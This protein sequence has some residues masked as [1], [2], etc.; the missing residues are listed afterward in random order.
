MTGTAQENA[1]ARG[2]EPAGG[3]GRLAR[4]GLSN[5]IQ[6]LAARARS[7]GTARA[8]SR[9]AAL[10]LK[11]RSYS[12]LA[13][14]CVPGGLSQRDLAEYLCLDPSQIVALVDGL[15]QRGLVERRADPR[16]RRSRVI[17][18]TAAGKNLYASATDAVRRAE[19]V[20][21]RNLTDGERNR[22][23]GLLRKMAL[24]PAD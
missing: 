7:L 23:R 21:L 1:A 5:E 2:R 24:T 20:S 19:E 17:H 12:V 13:L 8:D 11:V 16:D 6:F 3:A 15:E 14:A 18:A 9:L 10:D 22:L 4:S